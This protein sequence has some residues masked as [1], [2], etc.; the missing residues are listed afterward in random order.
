MTTDVLAVCA[1]A[2]CVAVAARSTWSPCGISMLATL[3]PLAE[4]GR[5]HRY[6]R[7]AAWF[8]AG[9]LAGG[10]TLGLPVGALAALVRSIAPAPALLEAMAMVAALVTLAAELGLGGFRLP[11]HHRQVNERW[12]DQFRLWVYAGGF[13]WQ[14]GTGLATY[15]M[16]PALYLMVLLAALTASPWLAFAVAASFG[17]LRGS[18]VL[19]GRRITD[20]ES[21]STFH[22]RF[23]H[24][25]AIVKR[26]LIAVECGV[27]LACALALSAWAAP[28]LAVLAVPAAATLRRMAPQATPRP[29]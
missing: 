4:R 12:L 19:L 8:V 5:G 17:L 26:A 9:G 22:Q 15:V 1:G 23:H 13:G 6:R 3:T 11:A 10:I 28:A 25:E 21:L 24:A 20:P 2:L 16:T 7:A 27:A 18:A 14:V 29:G